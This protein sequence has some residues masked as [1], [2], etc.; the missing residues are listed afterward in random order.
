MF[1]Y[2]LLELYYFSSRLMIMYS[3]DDDIKLLAGI[4]I[5]CI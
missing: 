3:K 2:V 5:L 4:R 1:G